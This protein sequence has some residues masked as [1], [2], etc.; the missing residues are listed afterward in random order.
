MA[1]QRAFAESSIIPYELAFN[2]KVQEDQICFDLIAKREFRRR[3]NWLI[4]LSGLSEIE[5]IK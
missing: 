4:L 3:R 1:G 2:Q 5:P